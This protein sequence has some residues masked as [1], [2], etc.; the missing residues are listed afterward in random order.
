MSTVRPASPRIQLVDALRGLASLAVVMVHYN[1]RLKW[2]VLE[3][4][5]LGVAVFFVLSGFV[6]TMSVGT[7]QIDARF[8]G[9]FALRRALRLD[10]PYWA[11]M[12]A[13]IGIGYAASGT[14]KFEG[15]TAPQVLAH[16]FYLQD[17]LGYKPILPVFWTLCYEVQFYLSLVLLLWAV[18]ASGIRRHGVLLVTLVLSVADRFYALTPAPFMGR[19]WFCFALGALVYEHYKQELRGAFV[20]VA[21]AAVFTFGLATSD[22]YAITSSLTAA[23]ISQ[24]LRLGYP[25]LLSGGVWQF[26][27][28][29]SYSLYLPHALFGWLALRVAERFV[30]T[31]VAAVFGTAV[32][33]VAAWFF[34][35]LIER[36]AVRLSHA[37]SVAPKQA[38]PSPR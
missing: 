21:I 4:G 27:G 30:P 13:V 23:V 7:A 3:L 28:R 10:P 6:V 29:I 26:L 22:G 37:V 38:V 16:M 9:R 34:Y 18:Q 11:T 20:Y 32:A 1:S 12:A 35:V 8:L 5:N 2:P 19:F 24:A 14:V 17:A 15:V 25:N 33:I 31:V 36:P